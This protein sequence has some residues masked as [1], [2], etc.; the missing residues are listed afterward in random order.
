MKKGTEHRH[1]N[2][3][4]RGF[5]A[6]QKRSIPIDDAANKTVHII[7]TLM[8]LLHLQQMLIFFFFLIK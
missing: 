3:R 6:T 1:R 7:A 8:Q 2:N 4:K 5:K